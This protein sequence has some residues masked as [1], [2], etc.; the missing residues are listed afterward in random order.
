VSGLNRLKLC[1]RDGWRSRSD[2]RRKISVEKAKILGIKMVH[3]DATVF[4]PSQFSVQRPGSP[5]GSGALPRL[6]IYS[7]AL[8]RGGQRQRR[9]LHGDSDAR[10][11]SDAR[12]ARGQR[13]L[14]RV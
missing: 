13:R 2:L 4:R 12:N 1:I 9:D 14:V 3:P 11:G 5:I 7:V 10:S 8:N 6:G